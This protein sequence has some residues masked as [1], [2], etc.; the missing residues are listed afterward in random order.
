MLKGNKGEWGEIY[1]FCYLLANGQLHAADKNLNSLEAV[2]FP[3]L[4]IIREEIFGNVYSYHNDENIKIYLGEKQIKEL[5]KADFAEVVEIL[6]EKIPLGERTFEISEVSEF[7]KSI[8]CTKLKASSAKKQD[9][10]IQIHDINTGVKPICGFSIKSYLGSN[11]TLINPGENTNFIFNVTCCNDD[12]MNSTNTIETRT[13]IIDKIR[14]LLEQGCEFDIEEHL[15]SGQFEENLGFIDTAMPKILSIAL[16]YSYK[17]KL[18]LTKAI[19]EKMKEL[20]P[21]NF[22]NTMMYEYI[23]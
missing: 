14:Y 8:Y 22:S 9:I 5:S 17:F 10:V 11:P 18:N 13:K 16:L 12:I 2:Y 19:I 7:F 21:L 1:A 23:F 4:K 15:I 3:I 20:N 6:Y